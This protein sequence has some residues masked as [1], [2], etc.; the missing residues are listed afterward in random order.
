MTIT[1]KR[2]SRKGIQKILT[3]D[4]LFERQE[5][6]MVEN[7][8]LNESMKNESFFSNRFNHMNGGAKLQRETERINQKSNITLN[9]N[10]N[11]SHESSQLNPLL[12]NNS[13]ES[14]ELIN[15]P[16]ESKLIDMFTPIITKSSSFSIIR[17]DI[18]E[19]DSTLSYN[20]KILTRGSLLYFIDIVWYNFSQ[21]EVHDTLLKLFQ[22]FGY[23]SRFYEVL[24]LC[25]IHQK[26]NPLKFIFEI[27]QYINSFLLKENQESF[28]IENPIHTKIHFLMH[29]FSEF[30][31]DSYVKF[32]FL[33]QTDNQNYNISISTNNWNLISQNSNESSEL[34]KSSDSQFDPISRKRTR[35]DLFKK[36][37]SFESSSD[38][39]PLHSKK[40][41]FFTSLSW[42]K[43]VLK[44]LLTY[45]LIFSNIEKDITNQNIIQISI[46]FGKLMS[47]EIGRINLI[48]LR[49][50]DPKFFFEEFVRIL[51]KCNYRKNMPYTII[52]K[53]FLNFTRN[54][55]ST[56]S[57]PIEFTYITKLQTNNSC[58]HLI[59]SLLINQ[60]VSQDIFVVTKKSFLNQIL[61]IRTIHPIQPTNFLQDLI[62]EGLKKLLFT[63]K[64]KWIELLLNSFA[65]VKF[66]DILKELKSELNLLTQTI[67][68]EYQD[69][70]S[71]TFKNIENHLQSKNEYLSTFMSWKI[72]CENQFN[73]NQ[74]VLSQTYQPFEVI[75]PE[76][77]ISFK[78]HRDFIYHI[79]KFCESDENMIQFNSILK[80]LFNNPRCINIIHLQGLI[81]DLVTK[82]LSLIKVVYRDSGKDYHNQFSLYISVLYLIFELL[83]F[84]DIP[85]HKAFLESTLKQLD[86]EPGLQA[87]LLNY[88]HIQSTTSKESPME[89]GDE[90]LSSLMS[91]ISIAEQFLNRVSPL[92][93]LECI[94]Y[95]TQ[96]WVIALKSGYLSHETAKE[97]IIRSFRI[98]GVYMEI[99]FYFTLYHFHR[100]ELNQFVRVILQL[101]DES[102]DSFHSSYWKYKIIETFLWL[103]ND[104]VKIREILNNLNIKRSII[105]FDEELNKLPSN[106][107]FEYEKW[108]EEFLRQKLNSLISNLSFPTIIQLK[109][110]GQMIPIDEYVELIFQSLPTNFFDKSST[111]ISSFGFEFGGLVG[112]IGLKYFIQHIL[113][114]KFS[115]ET[116]VEIKDRN[117]EYQRDR[118][119]D[120][121]KNKNDEKWKERANY[122][123]YFTF[124]AC[125][126]VYSQDQYPCI[127]GFLHYLEQSLSYGDEISK[128]FSISFLNLIIR[129]SC[130]TSKVL[131][132]ENTKL[133]E[134]NRFVNTFKIESK[135][136]N[137]SKSH[138]LR[139]LNFF[140]FE[141][142][143]KNKDEEQIKAIIFTFNE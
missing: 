47:S 48:S 96:Q 71:T 29:H 92:K 57:S 14:N 36:N 12:G 86:L 23:G 128:Y 123:A 117:S 11:S 82:I 52:L 4:K 127:D 75:A 41:S 143:I 1:K 121:Q 77:L 53:D 139:I 27:S 85:Q 20:T 115:E 84:R 83:N 116:I 88:V 132:S 44:V 65:Y 67:Q 118:K 24:Y 25:F 39:L 58:S 61:S 46:F 17:N 40:Q 125:I 42:L 7:G 133:E 95:V 50:N 98:Y 73:N 43:D 76:I 15:I 81:P 93:V 112:Y 91:D 10:K 60:L 78:Y 33:V 126:R 122:F 101:I 55:E 99:G 69:F 94:P 54:T 107:I 130:L 64:S 111:N 62:K 22:E 30:L 66:I 6:D 38:K 141:S 63:K 120:S 142:I 49:W 129:S 13:L 108:K 26:L 8:F 5:N 34:F 131:F 114:I 28:N 137:N 119:S 106:D 19:I 135:R 9:N 32:L 105:L 70:F 109:R 113:P 56:W 59:E 100:Y 35:E 18:I 110:F 90:L 45:M 138:D 134:R 87:S 104:E 51:L 37:L 2:S 3:E 124:Y 102:E 136:H 79:K 89:V 74:V 80:F 103:S 16:K 72:E 31:K 97:L 21:E 68:T 140:N